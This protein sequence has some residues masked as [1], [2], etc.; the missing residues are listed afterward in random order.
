MAK[1]ICA[2]HHLFTSRLNA[3]CLSFPSSYIRPPLLGF[4]L[5]QC[6]Q[7]FNIMRSIQQGPFRMV[8][9]ETS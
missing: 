6:Y 7:H 2:G 5:A 8:R 1:M 9:Y 4:S 3:S